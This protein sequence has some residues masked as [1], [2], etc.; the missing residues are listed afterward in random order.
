[1][2]KLENYVPFEV[3]KYFADQFKLVD[4]EIELKEACF[5]DY[6]VT[7]Y[8]WAAK[9]KKYGHEIT[10]AFFSLACDLMH[11]LKEKK[12]S[13]ADNVLAYEAILI[14]ANDSKV[15]PENVIMEINTH[16]QRT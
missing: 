15:F 5:L 2:A 1:M 8:W 7:Q 6:Y 12:M 4:Y 10:S 16:I 9:Q 3:E 14:E 13:F 11:N